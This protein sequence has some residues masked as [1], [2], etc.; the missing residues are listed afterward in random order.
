MD[1]KT[2]LTKSFDSINPFFE[3]RLE[4]NPIKKEAER[5][6]TEAASAEIFHD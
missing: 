4:K 2:E 3:I 5:L 6:K 1:K